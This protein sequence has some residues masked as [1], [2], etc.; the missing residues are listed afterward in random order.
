MT[1]NLSRRA[2]ALGLAQSAV[3]L[4]SGRAMA[5]L[6]AA[7]LLGAGMSDGQIGLGMKDLLKV[8]S[9]QTVGKLGRP[10]GFMGDPA[11]RIPLPGP[12]QQVQ[13]PL[14]M[15]GAGGMLDDLTRRMNRGAEQAMPKAGGIFATAANNL[16]FDDARQILTGPQD[17]VTQYFQRSCSGELTQA[18]TPVMGSALKGSGA[19]NTM[20][21]VQKKVQGIPMMGMLGQGLG[22]MGGQRGGFGGGMLQSLTN[23]DLTGFA[24]A[25]ALSGVFHYMGQQEADIRTNPAAR[26]TDMLKSLFR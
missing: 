21:S 22:Q 20:Q 4:W 16:T 9:R 23:F 19:M 18:F 24:T 26:S 25:A 3:L 1:R 17:S 10:N 5:Q 11:V 2:L 13:Q 12:L 7:S 8:T 14:A 6:S 15:A